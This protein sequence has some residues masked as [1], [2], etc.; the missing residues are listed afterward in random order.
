MHPDKAKVVSVVGNM[1]RELRLSNNL[2]IEKLAS[3]TNLEY[4]QIS[5]IERGKINTSVYHVY[6]ILT[7]LNIPPKNF[8]TITNKHLK[9][10]RSILI[11]KK[12]K[13]IQLTQ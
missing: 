11:K 4:S 1:I 13:Q 7:A 3:I 9:T 12:K 10:N 2:S 5:R 6:V 8:I